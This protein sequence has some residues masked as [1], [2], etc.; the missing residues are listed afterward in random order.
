MDSTEAGGF[1]LLGSVLDYRE[2]RDCPQE[3]AD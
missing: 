3:S 2:D 1:R